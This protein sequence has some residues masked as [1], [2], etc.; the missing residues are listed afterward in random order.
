MSKNVELDAAL[1]RPSDRAD[2]LDRGT[3]YGDDV[4]E[5]AVVLTPNL[6][7]LG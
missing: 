4:C 5:F 1:E 7:L 2:P 6:L 3:G